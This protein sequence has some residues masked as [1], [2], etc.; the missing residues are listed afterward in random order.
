MKPKHNKKRNTA[1]VYES[2]VKEATVAILKNDHER[3]D[4]VLSIIKKHFKRDSLLRKDL[5]IY[6]SLYENQSLDK[7]TSTRILTEAKI[8]S[9]LLDTQGVFVRQSDLIKDVNT[10]LSPSIFNNFVPNYKTL[11]SISQIFSGKLSPKQSVIL[12]NQLIDAMCVESDLKEVTTPTDSLVYNTLVS[13]FNDKYDGDLLKEQKQ[14]LSYFISSFSDNSLELKMFLNEE[15]SRLKNSL[16]EALETS[17]ISSDEQMIEKTKKVITK[18]DELYTTEISEHVL[19]TVLKTQ[20]L[21]GEI[22]N[23]GNHS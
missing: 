7:N 23:D 16:K 18:L 19:L 6:Q 22:N 20:T 8:A 3:R 12:E 10:E 1:F 4:R 9:R 15:I 11:A 13:K 14:M 17:E 2:L 5:E 21:V